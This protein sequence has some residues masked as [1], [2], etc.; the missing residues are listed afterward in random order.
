[1]CQRFH[2][3]THILFLCYK[4]TGPEAI[5]LKSLPFS[6]GP[7]PSLD[8]S[9]P[10]LNFPSPQWPSLQRQMQYVSLYYR[11]MPLHASSMV[12]DRMSPQDYL[13]CSL[14]GESDYRFNPTSLVA[15]LSFFSAIVLL[16]VK[17]CEKSCPLSISTHLGS[18]VLLLPSSFA[19]SSTYSPLPGSCRF[20]QTL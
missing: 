13:L 16:M 14:N 10:P 15:F 18:S 7:F 20:H 1:M 2:D 3:L 9:P 11:V 12:L 19:W 8:F 6:T 4:S 17:I 5:A